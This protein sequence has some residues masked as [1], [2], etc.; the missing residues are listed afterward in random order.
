MNVGQAFDI[1]VPAAVG[2]LAGTF[3]SRAVARK[4]SILSHPN[5][6]VA[7]HVRPVAYLGGVGVA[8]GV[9]CGIAIAATWGDDPGWRSDVWR[10]DV[11]IGAAAFLLLGLADDLYAFPPARKFMLQTAAAAFVG[12]LVVGGN[13]GWIEGL[14]A[15]V[16]ILVLTNGVNLVDVSDGLVAGLAVI[17]GLAFAFLS[18]GSPA[19]GLALAGACAGFLALNAPPA[20]IFLG[21]AG[22][23]LIGFLVAMLS[24]DLWRAQPAAVTATSIVLING[25]ILFELIFLVVVRSARGV[26]WWRGSPDHFALRMQAAG[27]SRWQVNTVAWSVAAA[28]AGL[29]WV[30]L[31]GTTPALGAVIAAL[32]LAVLA[33][34]QLLRVDVTPATEGRAQ[35]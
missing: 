15:S 33:W 14:T 7:Q 27:M 16:L 13:G 12:V 2:G 5:P 21:D 24:F 26:P 9:A 4:L 28:L 10:W 19:L 3:L 32:V 18:S 22:S 35:A 25:V 17:A 23:H 8:I 30:S 11:S 34:R 29:G 6:N 31:R 20:S 1:L